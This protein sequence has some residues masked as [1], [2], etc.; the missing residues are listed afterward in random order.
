MSS[1]GAREVCRLA[2]LTRGA[3][4]RTV[5]KVAASAVSSVSVM[6]SSVS[7]RRRAMVSKPERVVTKAR[8]RVCCLLELNLVSSTL[9]CIRQPRLR[10]AA[11]RSRAPWRRR[12]LTRRKRQ[13]SGGRE[14]QGR[15]NATCRQGCRVAESLVGRGRVLIAS[16]NQW[17][18]HVSYDGPPSS[19]M[20]VGAVRKWRGLT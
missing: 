8:E 11:V 4:G 20:S 19:K 12:G 1:G 10:L 7:W 6:S 3:G 9:S 18:A 17:A 16:A 2:G 13:T 5:L 14:A 15:K